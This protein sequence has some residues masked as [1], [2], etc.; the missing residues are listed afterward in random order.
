MAALKR[1]TRLLCGIGYMAVIVLALAALVVLQWMYNDAIHRA[2]GVPVVLWHALP[3]LAGK[4]VA[5]AAYGGPDAAGAGPVG[6]GVYLATVLA[7]WWF[8]P[9]L[10]AA[11]RLWASPTGRAVVKTY[12]VVLAAAMVGAATWL[13][14]EPSLLAS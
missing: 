6:A 8:L 10:A 12:V 7:A 4:F 13:F 9:A 14:L 11:P 3:M 2:I 1:G 5:D